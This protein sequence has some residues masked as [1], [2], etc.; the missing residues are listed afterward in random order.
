MQTVSAAVEEALVAP[1]PNEME[2]LFELAKI[3][4]MF[5]IQERAAELERLDAKYRPFAGKLFQLASAYQD[6]ELLA[7]VKL[8]WE[9]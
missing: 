1:P 6:K 3:G 5:G 7:F 8:H 9:G 2:L 4:N